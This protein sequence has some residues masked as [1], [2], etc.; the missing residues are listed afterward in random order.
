MIP[1]KLRPT[2]KAGTRI[3]PLALVLSLLFTGCNGDILPSDNKWI[4]SNIEGA[5]DTS[6]EYRVQDDFA[7]ANFM[8]GMPGYAVL[9]V[10][11]GVVVYVLTFLVLTAVF[12]N[13]KE[14]SF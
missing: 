10:L 7:A 8:L 12:F 6:D 9:K 5:V 13:K 4:D 11:I 3:L 2:R 1:F 14:L